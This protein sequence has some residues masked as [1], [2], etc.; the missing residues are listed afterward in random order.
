MFGAEFVKTCDSEF[1]ETHVLEQRSTNPPSRL[2]GHRLSA[3]RFLLCQE[4]GGNHGQWETRRQLPTG[5]DLQTLV[6]FGC[7][8][9]SILW[10]MAKVVFPAH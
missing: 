3:G 1:K 6:E 5:L 8:V 9:D 7:H 2:V 10:G 4:H